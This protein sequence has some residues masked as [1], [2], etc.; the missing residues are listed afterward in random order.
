MEQEKTST[1]GQVMGII[2]IVLGVISLIV[3]FIPCVGVVAFIPGVLALVFGIISISQASRENGSKGLGV[4][5]LIISII[6]II[7][8][9][10][11]L[12]I[13]SGASVIA[14]KII[15]NSDQFEKIGK[16]FEKSFNDEM[17]KNFDMNTVSDSLE[18]ALQE[19][20]SEMDKMEGTID[21]HDAHDAGKAAAKA[22]K[23]ATE[24]LRTKKDSTTNK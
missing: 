13:F 8:A 22:I 10:L 17:D 18:K 6:A 24:G 4:G 3:A 16:E 23:K 12:M 7:V 2:G 15:K 11:W 9:A 5:A 21:E 1:A 19:L 20:E 14:D